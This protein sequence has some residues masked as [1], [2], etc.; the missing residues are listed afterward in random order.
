MVDGVT[1]APQVLLPSL[2]VEGPQ[3]KVVSPGPLSWKRPM[4]LAVPTLL[5]L[6]HV[7]PHI[8]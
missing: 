1:A 8:R 5:A 7:L 6:C 2:G 3:E 4:L